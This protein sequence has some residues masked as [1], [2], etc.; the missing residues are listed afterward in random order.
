MYALKN[1]IPRSDSN[2]VRF[3]KGFMAQ[4]KLNNPCVL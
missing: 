3:L 2:A 1:S 4:K